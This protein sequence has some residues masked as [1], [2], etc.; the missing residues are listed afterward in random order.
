MTENTEMSGNAAYPNPTVSP[1]QP[2]PPQQY[3]AAYPNPTAYPNQ[4]PPTQQY[5]AAYP[6][7]NPGY[8]PTAP[9]YDA[10]KQPMGQGVP[11]G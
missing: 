8:P 6:N 7:P 1:N 2:P 3:N 11:A 10:T 5:N 4:P 9:A